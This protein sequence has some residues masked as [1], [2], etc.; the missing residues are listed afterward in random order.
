V[1]IDLFVWGFSSFL[2]Y[3]EDRDDTFLRNVS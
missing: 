2:F 3:P 1:Q